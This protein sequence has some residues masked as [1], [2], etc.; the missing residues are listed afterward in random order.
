MKSC[1]KQL[2]ITSQQT[3]RMKPQ[4]ILYLWSLRAV[5][6]HGA[7]P[8]LLP[9]S[10]TGQEG[11]NACS[12]RAAAEA[13]FGGISKEEIKQIINDKVN[14]QLN[15]CG[16]ILWKRIAHLD[17]RDSG[18]VC[19]TNWTLHTYPVR[20]CGQTWTGYYNCDSVFFSVSGQNYSRVCGR[21]LAYQKGS[22]DAF[23]N[24]LNRGKSSIDSAYVEGVS[25]THGPVGSR[26]HIWAFAAARYG[27]D[28]TYETTHN[29]PCTNTRYDWSYQLPSFI[30]NNYFCDTGNPGPGL[31]KSAYYSSDPLWDG[32]GCGEDSTCC[33]FNNPP[34]F[35]SSLPRAT[36]D[37]VEVRLC[38]SWPPSDEDAILYLLE[39][40]IQQ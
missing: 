14:P 9:P 1:I 25:V 22:T 40:F 16:S 7:F 12:S 26:Q 39:I 11:E 19:P 24:S 31:D 8:V 4:I 30:Q 2:R 17:M 13:Q 15:S 33:Q 32:A 10:V 21:I 27:E 35:Y 5:E 18:S 3:S 36:T 34:W 38:F 6:G 29:C 37:D 28:P 23:E 20:G